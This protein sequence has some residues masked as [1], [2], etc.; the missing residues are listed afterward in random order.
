MHAEVRAAGIAVKRCEI[1]FG[2]EQK[3]KASMIRHLVFIVFLIL[4]LTVA[5]CGS[6]GNQVSVLC[7]TELID[8][9]NHWF[10]NDGDF[11]GVDSITFDL[12]FE[13][14][15]GFANEFDAI[16]EDTIQLWSTPSV[17]D[18]IPVTITTSPAGQIVNPSEQFS[19]QFTIDVSGLPDTETGFG[20]RPVS[21]TQGVLGTD[22]LL[23]ISS[24][25]VCE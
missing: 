16:P 2:F 9:G 13:L 24:S 7:P 3:G 18:I 20:F 4:S 22:S 25:F 21:I 8:A 12:T 11:V 19:Y 23:I 6:G 1:I 10:D 15:S 14:D 17:I 5:G